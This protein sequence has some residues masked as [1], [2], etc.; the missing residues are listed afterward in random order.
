MRVISG[1]PYTLL[2][3]ERTGHPSNGG[4]KTRFSSAAHP[5]ISPGVM[6]PCRRLVRSP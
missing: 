1:E 4:C 2:I 6:P 5:L 3:R